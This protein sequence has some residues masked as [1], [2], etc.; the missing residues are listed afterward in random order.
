MPFH[1]AVPDILSSLGDLTPTSS[2][3]A[4]SDLFAAFTS[5]A[6]LQFVSVPLH[7]LEI[8]YDQLVAGGLCPLSAGVL[9]FKEFILR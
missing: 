9:M 8:E 2:D 6:I 1:L 3:Q 7:V 5:L 4:F